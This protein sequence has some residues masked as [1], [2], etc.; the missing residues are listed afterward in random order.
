ML[1]VVTGQTFSQGALV[2]GKG[3]GFINQVPHLNCLIPA[4]TAHMLWTQI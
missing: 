1:A 3:F 4:K 2:L